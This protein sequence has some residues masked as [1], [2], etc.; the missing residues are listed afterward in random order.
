MLYVCRIA[1]TGCRKGQF[2]KLALEG[3]QKEKLF[4]S[5]RRMFNAIAAN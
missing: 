2:Y 1:L 5:W 4:V 3:K